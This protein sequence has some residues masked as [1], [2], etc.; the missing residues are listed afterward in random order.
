MQKSS[1]VLI[2]LLLGFLLGIVSTSGCIDTNKTNNVWGEKKISLDAIKTSN[3]TTGRYSQVNE[4]NY[5]VY[6]YLE[7]HNPYDALD[8]KVKITL[9]SSNG[10]VIAVNN[11]PHL[12]TP[13]IPA[14]GIT[15]YYALFTDQD[16][17]I[18][19]YKVKVIDAK[20]QY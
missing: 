4:S 5:F 20:A 18:A 13:S 9:Y 12:D 19:K 14:D 16:N 3:N 10:T 8:V 7:N 2:I 1:M 11:T 6:G 15:Y 17:K